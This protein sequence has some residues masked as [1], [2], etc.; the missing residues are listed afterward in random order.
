M[1]IKI[2]SITIFE[3]LDPILP[4]C[5]ILVEHF[6]QLR[7]CFVRVRIDFS[8]IEAKGGNPIAGDFFDKKKED[9]PSPFANSI[10]QDPM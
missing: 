6:S 8:Q 10:S 5:E 2:I 4:H 7:L 9:N 3:R 1:R